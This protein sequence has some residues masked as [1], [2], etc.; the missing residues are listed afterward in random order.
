MLL[1]LFSTFCSLIYKKI[2]SGHWYLGLSEVTDGYVSISFLSF[3]LLYHNLVP[4]SMVIQIDYV[5]F[6]QAWFINCDEKMH[7]KNN[8]LGIDAYAKAR[9]SALNEELG[10]IEYVFTDKTG[11]LT[12]NVMKFK[13]CSVGGI[14]HDPAKEKG[15]NVAL[16]GRPD[17][18]SREFLTVMTICHSVIPEQTEEGVNYLAAS[19]DEKAL[20][21]GAQLYG[22][23]F[24][25]R[26]LHSVVIINGNGSEEVYE[27]LHVLSF[28]SARKRMS[29][30]VRTPEGKI[31]L[32]S[33]GA[34]TAILPLTPDSEHLAATRQHLTEFSRAGLRT[35]C[36]ATGDLTENE[37]TEWSLLCDEAEAEVEERE[38]KVTTV[39][40]LIEQKRLRLLG[41]TAIEDK[42]QDGVPETIAALLEANIKVWLLTGD[43]METAINI[44]TACRLHPTDVDVKLLK[45][46]ARTREEA[47]TVLRAELADQCQ[48][49]E[50]T[51]VVDGTSLCF[52]LNSNLRISFFEVCIACKAVICCR[53][54]P[55]QKAEIVEL[56][57][58]NSKA[59]TLAI[60]D[61]GNDVAMIQKAAVGIGILGNE[62]RQAANNADYSI[63]QFSFLRRLLF[64]HGAWSY[65]RISKLV[66]FSFYKNFTL[67][68]ME[69]WFAFYS[70]WSGMRLFE[71]WTIAFFNAFCTGTP[72]LALG[73]MD[74]TCTAEQRE[75]NPRLYHSSQ[76]SEAFNTR[77]F[78]KWIAIA[79]F[80]SAILFWMPL[81]A[82][83]TG[84]HWSNG[85]TGGIL[86][87]GNTVYSL[88]VITV[89]F[90]AAIEMDAWVWVSHVFIWGPIPGWFLIF[91]IYSHWWPGTGKAS[92]MY[93]MCEAVVS[94]STFWLCVLLVPWCALQLDILLR[95]SR[96]TYNPTVTDRMRMAIRRKSRADL[97]VTSVFEPMN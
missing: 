50:T 14:V 90:K 25:T 85:Q 54:S 80:H 20:V 58:E 18:L 34:D 38:E 2:N 67:I 37:Y 39:W 57:E 43:K 68:F 8:Q 6:Y 35:L 24:I 15:E 51:L 12:R 91:F 66:L 48:G 79:I 28:S 1:A 3:I 78:W 82:L 65:N 16:A 13:M 81:F 83:Q 89:C 73:L 69:L 23:K 7:Y 41:A 64:V 84:V 56:V 29:V 63:A 53:M 10:Q 74:Q 52:F 33:K 11:T 61:G 31:K 4:F 96:E 49:K 70:Y 97:D 94:S 72:P 5:K 88:L 71:V 26:T 40:E 21:E 27:V 93:A 77:E 19:A 45:L 17:G 92:H 42:L 87:L 55:S 62:G 9:T 22:Y 86:F 46:I 44:A 95:V 76:E 59:V 75:N 36:M 60:G 47:E 32:L 30:V